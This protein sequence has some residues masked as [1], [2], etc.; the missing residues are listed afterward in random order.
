MDDLAIRSGGASVAFPVTLRDALVPIFRRRRL[1]SLV[2][3]GIF[4][5]A[6]LA[7]VLMPR[8]YESEMKILL[9]R[10][11][12][13]A[14]VTPDPNAPAPTAA[15]MSVSEEDINS[16]VELIKS[17]DL[18]SEV[19]RS[20]DLQQARS[21]RWR[22][23]V[24]WMSRAGTS[25]DARL[26]R[27]V[28]VLENSLSVEPLKKTDMIRVAYASR[29]PQLSARVLQSLAALYQEKHAAV[30]RPAGT[31]RFFDEETA[32]HRDELVAA[33]TRL[34]DFDRAQGVIAADTQKQLVLQQLSQFQTDFQQ[35]KSAERAAVARVQALRAR[36]AATPERQTT[37][38][39]TL[40][41]A[42]LL[43]E[44]ESSLL[45]LELKRS[46]MSMKYAPEYPPVRA[47]DAEISDTR[48]AIAGA[49]QAPVEEKTTD[50]APA[51]D[52]IATELAKAEADRAQFEAHAAATARTIAHFQAAAQQL[53][54]K[55]SVQ[56]DLARDVRASE[57]DYLLYLRKREEARI[58]DALDTRRIVNVSVAEAAT[59]PALPTLHLAWLLVGGFFVASTLSL[60]AAYAADR[61]DPSFRTPDELQRYLA[62]R[63]LAA[64]PNDEARKQP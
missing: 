43:A 4:C 2:F 28:R 55:S 46:E 6:I 21:P 27:A 37:Q 15:V 58:S 63:V 18:L 53:D 51:Q 41:N 54:V 56:A 26:A 7:A 14:V 38:V 42:Q 44:L 30:H 39:R 40:D 35:D 10:D 31:F 17:R 8:T 34:T 29:D 45:S 22:R 49:R 23:M 57:S 5:G 60:G 62:T 48:A 13:D 16:E 59:V 3:V 64:I 36:A 11:R 9:N 12:A 52:W 47:L 19:V 25:D 33:E 1:A 50:R 32:K 61:M 20:C 24:D